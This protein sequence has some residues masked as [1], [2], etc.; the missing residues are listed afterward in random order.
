M[1]T[2]DGM[3]LD[4]PAPDGDK[5]S[6]LWEETFNGKDASFQGVAMGIYGDRVS[7]QQF[8]FFNC[9]CAVLFG[10]SFRI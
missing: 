9:N 8:V 1:Q 2:W 7:L 4:K 5:I 3:W 10:G 6:H